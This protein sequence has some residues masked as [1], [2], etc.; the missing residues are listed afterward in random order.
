MEK[1]ALA[2]PEVVRATGISRSRLYQAMSDGELI[3]R[4]LGK[5][6]LFL[7]HELEAF[8]KN[9]PEAVIKE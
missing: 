4:K 8:L 7:P 6:I 9:L 1:M 2:L 3:G 5:R